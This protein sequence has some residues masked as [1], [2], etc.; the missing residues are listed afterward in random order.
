MS[1]GKGVN[2]RDFVRTAMAAGSLASLAA[3][4]AAQNTPAAGT[5][6]GANSRIN[7]GIIGVGGRGAGLMRL[8]LAMAEERSDLRVT[9]VCDVYEKRKRLAQE[10]SKA[11]FA[12][13]DYREVLARP[14]PQEI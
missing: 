2:R 1:D 14:T 13:L 3:G 8:I 5:A 11:P 6:A 7:I 12:T 4:A 10:Q 9:A